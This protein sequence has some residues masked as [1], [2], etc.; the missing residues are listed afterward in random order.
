MHYSA[1]VL[2]ALKF[3]A[4]PIIQRLEL[5]EIDDFF[6]DRLGLRIF[7]KEGSGS[8]CLVLFG[9]CKR[10]N[11][12]RIG[13][14]FASIAAWETIRLIKPTIIISAGTAGGFKSKGADIGDVF[15]S[16]KH[17]YFHGRHIP[18]PKYSTFAK[19][20][21]TVFSDIKLSNSTKVKKGIISS[22]DSIPLTALDSQ[23][24]EELGT[25]AKDME[26]AAIAEV[27]QITG[28]NVIALKCISDF[29]DIDTST[30]LQVRDNFK[31]ALSNLTNCLEEIIELNIR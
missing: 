6:D 12:D 4:E 15:L 29:I 24:M 25:D 11:V 13:T 2:C 20:E 1:A 27:A 5:K 26:A 10:N 28:T 30:H 8:L 22:G 19:G 9:K 3:E 31:L 23:L 14:Q 7:A 17:I 16:D 18:V 21:F